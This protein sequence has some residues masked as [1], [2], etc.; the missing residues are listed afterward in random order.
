MNKLVTLIAALLISGSV[1]AQVGT[2]VKEGAKATGETAKQVGDDVKGAVSSEPDKSIDK[3]K[4]KAHKAKAHQHAHA[5]KEAA[6]E[7]VK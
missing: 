4:A 3:T 1:F 7:A 2:A 5:A 6:K